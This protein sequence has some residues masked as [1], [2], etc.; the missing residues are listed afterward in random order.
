M[1]DLKFRDLICSDALHALEELEIE[2]TKS[3]IQ[4]PWER[5]GELFPTDDRYSEGEFCGLVGMSLSLCVDDI[6]RRK[7]LEK[8]IVYLN[9]MP[10]NSFLERIGTCKYYCQN[11]RDKLVRD[12]IN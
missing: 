12:E 7:L 5:F 10:T 2:S 9:S 11:V 8:F 3:M 6:E 4:F 1:P